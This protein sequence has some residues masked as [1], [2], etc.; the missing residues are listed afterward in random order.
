MVI[1][2]YATDQQEDKP[3]DEFNCHCQIFCNCDNCNIGNTDH[4]KDGTPRD[5]VIILCSYCE[6]KEY[7]KQLQ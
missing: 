6:S 2:G 1:I 5:A 7:Y 3:V 4:M